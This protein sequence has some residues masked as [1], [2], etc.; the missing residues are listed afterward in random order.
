MK[1]IKK[2]IKIICVIIL[3]LFLGLILDYIRLNISYKINKYDYSVKI[4]GNKDKYTP[5]GLTYSSKYNVIIS[6]SYNSK[7]LVSKVYIIDFD[8]NKLLKEVELRNTD[9]T[10]NKKHV[11]GITTDNKTLWITND[12][13]V[14]EYDLKEIINTNKKY[15]VS[16]KKTKLLNRGDLCTYKDNTLYIGDFFLN[17]FYKIKDNNPL[18]MAFDTKNLDYNKPKYII[19]LPKMVQ[20]LAITD[21]NNIIV[22]RSFTNLIKS[23]LSIYNNVIENK[24]SYYTLNNK[25]I[26]Y[27]KLNKNNKIKSIK[28]PPMAEELFYKDNDLYIL[29]ENSSDTYFYAYPKIKNIM[30]ININTLIKKES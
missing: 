17:P 8:N 9:N 28:L 19:S 4:Y 16:K 26:P 6:S 11:G 25:K 18:L 29:F 30:K 7:H 22:T 1:I 23:D 27:Y 5:Q 13:E 10:I 14:N 15:V 2:L 24:K 21:D 3:I 12:F 20:G